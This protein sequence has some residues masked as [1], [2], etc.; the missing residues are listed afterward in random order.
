MKDTIGVILLDADEIVFYVYTTDE[1]NK[2]KLIKHQCF[3]LATGIPGKKATSTEY[4]EIIAKTFLSY[5]GLAVVD[6]KI[7]ARNINEDILSDITKAT[8][9][10]PEMLTLQREQ[11][12]V[13]KGLLGEF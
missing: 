2:W 7:C 12:L 4:I 13:S 3:D 6:W 8:G 5:F 9:F 11:E 10:K 1:N